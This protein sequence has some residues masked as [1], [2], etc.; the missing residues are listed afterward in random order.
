[1]I[2]QLASV[3]ALTSV[4]TFAV[5]GPTTSNIVK[6]NGSWGSNVTMCKFD[7]IQHGTME[8]DGLGKW[9]VTNV[10]QVDLLISN[11]QKIDVDA[12]TSVR[13]TSNDQVIGAATVNYND[14]TGTTVRVV[15]GSGQLSNVTINNTAIDANQGTAKGK[16]RIKLGGSA[17]Q[18]TGVGDVIPGVEYYIKHTVTCEQ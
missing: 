16:V 5:A 14:G 8:F 7:D 13:Q 17:T 9:N 11:I 2:K 12:D 10:A 6:W 1:M 4:A 15:E 3:M 18:T